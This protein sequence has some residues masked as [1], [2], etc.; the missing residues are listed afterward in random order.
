M[1]PPAIA[2]MMTMSKKL[3]RNI[4]HAPRR[5]G[6]PGRATLGL[7][8]CLFHIVARSADRSRG[9]I[10]DKRGESMEAQTHR[11]RSTDRVTKNV[12]LHV[13]RDRVWHAI[14]DPTQF[15]TWFGMKINGRFI[16]GAN[17][18]G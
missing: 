11:A 7:Q 16:P 18:T 12:L 17:V 6:M 9:Y 5:C 15:G 1:L 4:Q 13:P 8:H 2:T 14:S 10:S 3:M